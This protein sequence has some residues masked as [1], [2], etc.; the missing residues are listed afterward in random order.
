VLETATSFTYDGWNL[1]KETTTDSGTS[2]DYYVWGLDVSGSLQGA[3]GIGGLLSKTNN[4]TSTT[5]LYTVDANGNVGQLV[6][7][8]DGTIAAHHEYD[9]FGNTLV[10]SCPEAES[11]VFR[12]STKYYDAEI[13][14][15]YYGYRY[16]SPRLGRWV[17][18]DP[19]GDFAFFNV[20][21]GLVK[22]GQDEASQVHYKWKEL[23]RRNL[24]EDGNPYHFCWNSP[25]DTW[26]YL[27]LGSEWYRRGRCCNRSEGDEWALVAEG[28]DCGKWRKLGPGEC[29][30]GY[31]G[32][33]D[34]EGMTCGGGFYY[35][36][37]EHTGTCKTPGCDKW[38]YTT[39]RRWTPSKSDSNARSP[40]MRGACPDEGDIPPDY[41]YS[42]RQKC[43]EDQ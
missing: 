43:C 36:G 37:V 28:E 17:T 38:P 14:L 19:I 33:L 8:S 32:D 23:L 42:D 35:V 3:G 16:Y 4:L 26:D 15:Y 24:P 27:G 29:V 11:N 22:L 34:C 21:G 7:A 18:R 12:F 13:G 25:A 20:Q 6:D 1:I 2:T 5:Y 31:F 30:G 9:P 41:E 40:R 10:A 39:E